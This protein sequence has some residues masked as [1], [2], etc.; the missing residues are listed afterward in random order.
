MNHNINIRI[1]GSSMWEDQ[2]VAG[3]QGDANA[4]TLEVSLHGEWTDCASVTL[5]FDDAS[6]NPAAKLLLIRYDPA[7]G[8]NMVSDNVFHVKLP[9][10]AML[11]PGKIVVTARGYDAD[12]NV[13]RK[14]SRKF[15]VLE[16]HADYPDPADPT[17]SR[18]EQLLALIIKLKD[19][20]LSAIAAVSHPA[21]IN[22]ENNHWMVWDKETCMYV[23]SGVSSVHIV[24]ATD[25][26]D[27][28]ITTG[29]LADGAV[30]TGKLADGA[31]TSE[32]LADGAVTTGKIADGAV[33][34]EKMSSG[35]MDTVMNAYQLKFS[36][37]PH[38]KA[39]YSLY[40][41]TLGES[42]D[43]TS[44]IGGGTSG[45]VSSETVGG[46]SDYMLTLAECLYDTGNTA[47]V[48]SESK[49]KIITPGIY[50]VWAEFD[51]QAVEMECM[52]RLRLDYGGG[53]LGGA[54]ARVS[55]PSSSALS[56]S[57]YSHHQLGRRVISVKQGQTCQVSV[58]LDDVYVPDEQVATICNV[59]VFIEKVGEPDDT[60]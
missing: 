3:V 44:T 33:T 6:G 38:K 50:M 4:R 48:T 7:D 47:S 60:E 34:L 58:G 57:R 26:L 59:T 2:P 41:V 20:M 36:Q 52:A 16:N 10:E 45:S 13:I 37:S 19:T 24:D 5:F 30:T 1:S 14:A 25:L 22:S 39:A 43:V 32:K 11:Y 40:A 18:A 8:G 23:D 49:L 9:G 31:A 29:F 55:H 56:G 27:N 54:L 15:V 46:A 42:L 17:P 12:G 21:Y 53:V 35:L 28:G 51:V